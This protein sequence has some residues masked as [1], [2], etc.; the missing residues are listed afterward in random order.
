[1]DKDHVKKLACLPDAECSMWLYTP[2]NALIYRSLDWL[3]YAELHIPL[4]YDV[5]LSM[6]KSVGFFYLIGETMFLKIA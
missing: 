1:M 2:Y 5:C 4:I 3:F 6:V